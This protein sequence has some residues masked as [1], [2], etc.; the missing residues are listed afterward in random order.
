MVS[1]EHMDDILVHYKAVM[2][3]QM[4]MWECIAQLQQ[5]LMPELNIIWITL[6]IKRPH[7]QRE[8]EAHSKNTESTEQTKDTNRKRNHN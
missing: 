1:D 2:W 3:S 7:L 6:S 4:L 5:V 8:G